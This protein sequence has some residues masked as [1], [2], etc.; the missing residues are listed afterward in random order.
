MAEIRKHTRPS[1][2]SPFAQALEKALGSAVRPATPGAPPQPN[3]ADQE[4]P[5]KR[6]TATSLT[7]TTLPDWAATAPDDRD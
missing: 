1:G 6:P 5:R 4:V 7:T 2:Q 3:R